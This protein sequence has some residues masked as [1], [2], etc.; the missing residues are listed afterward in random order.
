VDPP[1]AGDAA[2]GDTLR[3]VGFFILMAAL[4]A[5]GVLFNK[6]VMC[7]QPVDAWVNGILVKQQE[8]QARSPLLSALLRRRVEVGNVQSIGRSSG[9]IGRS[10]L[11]YWALSRPSPWAR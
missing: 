2:S 9:G 4:V 11:W 1:A 5:V 8:R 3:P 7:R 6:L 10:S